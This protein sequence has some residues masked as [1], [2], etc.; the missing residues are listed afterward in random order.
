MEN[1]VR[2]FLSNTLEYEKISTLHN[3]VSVNKFSYLFGLR[4]EDTNMSTW[5]FTKFNN[6]N[7][8]FFP[9]FF[10]AYEISDKVC[11]LKLQQTSI[12]ET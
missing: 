5:N 8:V 9:T 10:A 7:T 12:S 4:W 1:N 6:K 11:I 3:M 2:Q